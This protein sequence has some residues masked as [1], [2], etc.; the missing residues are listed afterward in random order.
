MGEQNSQPPNVSLASELF[1]VKTRPKILGNDFHI[2]PNCPK[3]VDKALIQ[4]RIY[5]HI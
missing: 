1:W 4:E 2:S 5:Y 3:N